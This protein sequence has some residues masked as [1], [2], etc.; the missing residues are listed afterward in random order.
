MYVVIVCTE[1]I[2]VLLTTLLFLTAVVVSAGALQGSAWAEADDEIA[3]AMTDPPKKQVDVGVQHGDVLCREGYVLS[4]RTNNDPVCTM[5]ET[6]EKLLAR[7]VVDVILGETARPVVPDDNDDDADND[8]DSDNSGPVSDDDLGVTLTDMIDETVGEQ[9]AETAHAQAGQI[10]DSSASSDVGRAQTEPDTKPWPQSAVRTIPASTMS[11]VNFYITDDDLNIAR[12]A[13]EVIP[14]DGLF[15]FTINGVPIPG[16]DSII[17][18]GP[19]T[20]QFYVRLELPDM[21][22]GRPLNQN[23]VVRVTYLD[24]TDSSGEPRAVSDSFALSSTYAQVQS[25]VSDGTRIGHE[26]TLRV[27]EP[28]ANMDSRDENKIPLGVLEFK[29]EGGIRTTLANPAF[30]ARASHLVETGPN[31]GIFEV[32]MKIPRMIDGEVVHIGD[33]YE[34]IYVDSSTPSGTVEDIVLRGTIGQQ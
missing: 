19:N 8:T 2:G 34:I 18:T 1:A 21:I 29:S 31:T 27:Y 12:N 11:V 14:A 6:A 5:P 9:E 30:D 24:K 16:P 17:E 22:D 20:G 3:S 13:P 25:T 4:I 23:D 32:K 7:G 33:W 15:L 26:F 10:N 28:D